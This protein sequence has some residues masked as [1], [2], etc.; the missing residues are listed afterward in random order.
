MPLWFHSLN[1]VCLFVYV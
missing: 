1:P